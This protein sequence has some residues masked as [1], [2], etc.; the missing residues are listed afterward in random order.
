[1]E[2]THEPAHHKFS[3]QVPGGEGVILYRRGPDNSY[4]LY[5]TEVPVE[6]RGKNVAD[7]LM[8]KALQTAKDEKVKIIPT[9]PYVERWFDRH[10]DE[11][12]ILWH[13]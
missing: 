8:R 9:C 7:Q 6:A 2:I 4:D 3:V 12:G 5:A 1:M 10:P 13:R 11:K